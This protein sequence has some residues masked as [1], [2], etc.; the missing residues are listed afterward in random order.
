MSAFEVT[1]ALSNTHPRSRLLWKR[2]HASRR[3]TCSGGGT[4]PF[5]HPVSLFLFRCSFLLMAASL[6][7]FLVVARSRFK[8]EPIAQATTISI[9]AGNKASDLWRRFIAVFI[10]APSTHCPYS[11]RPFKFASGAF[12]CTAIRECNF[13][14][15]CT[16]PPEEVA[17]Q[18][19]YTP[20]ANKF[21]LFVCVFFFCW[22][23]G[24][25]EIWLMLWIG[26]YAFVEN[27]S[28]QKFV[29]CALHVKEYTIFKV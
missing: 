4:L 3:S 18:F 5:T 11:S 25:G 26:F 6:S 27:L 14:T 16:L 21:Q 13:W 24:S 8:L 2:A 12:G 17:L 10:A 23:L 19:L 22:F 29:E 1:R 28:V 7:M 20:W 9:P 15:T